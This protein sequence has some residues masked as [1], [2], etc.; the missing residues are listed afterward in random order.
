[1]L[2]PD[3]HP[4]LSFSSH[5]DK[6]EG[7]LVS[8]SENIFVGDLS[9]N[10]YECSAA[11]HGLYERSIDGLI[12]FIVN[13]RHVSNEYLDGVNMIAL[14]VK[15]FRD[16]KLIP[17]SR[18]IVGIN[19]AIMHNRTF[20]EKGA[21]FC[22]HVISSAQSVIY[23][24][25]RNFERYIWLDLFA[26]CGKERRPQF[27]DHYSRAL[28]FASGPI[29]RL[30]HLSLPPESFERGSGGEG[31]LLSCVSRVLSLLV[32]R[33]SLPPHGIQGSP[34]YCPLVAHFNDLRPNK[35]KRTYANSDTKNTYYGENKIDPKQSFIVTIFGRGFD[36]PYISINVLLLFGLESWATSLL[37]RSRRSR[38]SWFMAIGSFLCLV[39]LGISLHSQSQEQKRKY[40]QSL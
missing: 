23:N 27:P 4:C 32:H 9:C 26:F 21:A 24:H 6:V 28:A 37:C 13:R 22:P 15:N 8:L 29:L 35:Q 1:M 12:K 5:P 31:R 17:I 25:H 34:H 18:I 36:D 14:R 7:S 10:S 33:V 16:K 2:L 39:R 40:R 19:R 3:T 11:N 20:E 38:I 30:D